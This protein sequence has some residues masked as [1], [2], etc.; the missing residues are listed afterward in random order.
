M[1]I[2]DT[3]VISSLMQ[4]PAEPVVVSWL[5]RQARSSIWTSSVTVLE[6]RYGL[7]IMAPGRRR[8]M[9]GT[10]FDLFLE[11]IGHRIAPFDSAAAEQ[12]AQ[13]MATRK[14]KGQPIELRDSMIAGITIA[15]NASLATRNVSDFQGVP[16]LINPWV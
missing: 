6:I 10:M 13:L 8:L 15:N 2:L 11:R 14:K 16:V 12:C 3:N 1:V 7:E 9:L 4:Q 5:D